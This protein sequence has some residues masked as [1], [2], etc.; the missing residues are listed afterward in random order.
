MHDLDG[1]VISVHGRTWRVPVDGLPREVDAEEGIAFGVA[2][3]GG[4]QHLLDIPSGADVDGILG[5]IDAF[6]EQTHIDHAQ[7]VCA[8]E[9]TGTFTE[10]V[11][12]TVAPPTHEGESLGEVIDDEIRFSFP[13]WAGTLVGFRFPDETDGQTIPGLH[14][15]AISDDASTGGHVRNA[16]TANVTARIWVDD[17]HPVHEHVDITGVQTPDDTTIDF[18]RYE[19]KVD[20]GSP[21]T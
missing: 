1:E 3:H 20:Q 5:T 15:H 7:V 16:T 10:V 17:L 18:H 6:L 4:R 9:I 11:L 14:L 2:A 13:E 12:R 8:V 19:G 21:T